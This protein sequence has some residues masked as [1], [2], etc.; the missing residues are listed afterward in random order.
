MVCATRPQYAASAAA[1]VSAVVPAAVVRTADDPVGPV[2]SP[3]TPSL[4]DEAAAASLAKAR[5][6]GEPSGRPPL[7]ESAAT[8]TVLEC[9]RQ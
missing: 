9:E 8:S 2:V 4:D 3:I 7:D 6:G 5:E 1:A